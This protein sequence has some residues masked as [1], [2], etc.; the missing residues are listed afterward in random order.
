MESTSNPNS[1]Q[2]STCGGFKM[3]VKELRYD[4]FINHFKHPLGE[5]IYKEL[6]ALE[7]KVFLTSEEIEIGDDEVEAA[8][9]SC[10]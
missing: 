9:K 7:L 8:F 5:A 10:W 2:P 1:H 4:V 3:P 6:D